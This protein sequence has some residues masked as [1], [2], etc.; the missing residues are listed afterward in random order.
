MVQ[1][2]T[3]AD[4]LAELERAMAEH[5]EAELCE[6]AA[7]AKMNSAVNRINDAQKA[8]DEL[9]AATRKIAPWNTRWHSQDRPGMPVTG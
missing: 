5:H 1:T 8:I 7:R 2:K 9:V 6:T 3:M 4:L